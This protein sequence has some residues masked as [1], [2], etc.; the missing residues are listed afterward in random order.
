MNDERL[1][2]Q[3]LSNPDQL[4]GAYT[5]SNG[6]IVV[7][8]KNYKY[9]DS[10]PAYS[11]VAFGSSYVNMVVDSNGSGEWLHDSRLVVKIS[12]MTKTGGTY[13]R[14][15]N[16]LALFMFDGFRLF[17]DSKEKAYVTSDMVFENIYKNVDSDKWARIAA[18]IGYDTTVGN[19]NTLGAS[20]QMFAI[21]LK[22]M[23]NMF[24]KPIDIENLKKIEIRCYLKANIA[25]CLQTDGTAPTFTFNAFYLDNEYIT[26]DPKIT[27]F[28]RALAISNQSPLSFDYEYLDKPIQIASGATTVD[29]PLTELVGKNV[30]DI[31]F[32]IRANTSINTVLTSDYTDSNIAITTWNL[33]NGNKFI[34]N[35]QQDVTV[36]PDYVRVILARL[37]FIGIKQIL[38]RT[39]PAITCS[40]AHD[41]ST[42]DTERS[43]KYNGYRDFTG[44]ATPNLHLTFPA[45]AAASQCNVFVR[46][47]KLVA[48]NSGSLEN[49]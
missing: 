1:Q 8:N 4:L 20:S 9:V 12:A 43:Q 29:I 33:K 2:K 18:D 42:S 3:I 14:G 49:L 48:F 16:S 15:V 13:C 38:G 40:F 27:N 21:P 30:I 32:Q 11:S 24:S 36:V 23:F 17:S 19:R 22:Y 6:E 47:V 34:T 41:Y 28:S 39:N 35:L 37:H 10:Q 26:A 46:M 25:F 31:C 7:G 44:I 45:L 5:A